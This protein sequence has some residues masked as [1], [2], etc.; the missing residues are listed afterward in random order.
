MVQAELPFV[1]LDLRRPPGPAVADR[2]AGAV[3]AGRGL[4]PGRHLLRGHVVEAGRADGQHHRHRRA[5]P[6]RG[7]PHG[8]RQ[9][10]QPDPLLPGVVV[11]D[12]R[13]GPRDP[14]ERDDARS[15]PARPTAWPR[16]S[17]TRSPSTTASPTACTPATAS[18][19]T[20][21]RSGAGMEFVT[22]KVST[23]S[24]ASSSACR[25][26]WSWATCSPSGTGATPATTSRRCGPCSSRTS[27][28]TTW[29]PR[30]RPTP[31]RSSSTEAFQHA[32]IE[33]W[34]PLRPPGPALPPPGRGRPPGRRRRQGPRG[35]RLAAGG[36]L[37]RA[38]QAHGGP[39]PEDR[40]DQA[41]PGLIAA[42]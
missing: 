26:S 37:L 8:R 40:A 41:R 32:G 6:A 31:S 15:T 38:G 4:Q 21:S 16:C 42:R 19:S 13:Q 28:T 3:A 24:P 29:W 2:R 18:C 9:P 39:R 33:D 23:R 22:R 30:A 1:E 27:P 25:R 35:A 34:Q 14:A 36:R 10:G 7:H 5:A 20:T 12:V 17:A 11:G